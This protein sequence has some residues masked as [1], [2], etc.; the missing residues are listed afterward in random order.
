[1]PATASLFRRYPHPVLIE[2]GTWHGDGIAAALEA[3]FGRV[4]SIELSEDLYRAARARFRGDCRVTLCHGDSADWL[5][6]VLAELHQPATFWLDAHDSGGDTARGPEAS[7][8]LRELDVIAAWP[9]HA[10]AVLIDDVR[11]FGAD[12][13]FPLLDVEERLMRMHADYT[14][15]FVSGA[16]QTLGADILA[17]TR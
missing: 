7:P 11:L 14:L 17:A 10:D 5:P 2:T 1:M 13:P 12:F 8:L 9:E 16:D 15:E 3:G 4:V 6:V